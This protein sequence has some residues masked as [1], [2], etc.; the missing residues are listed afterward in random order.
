[1]FFFLCQ[2]VKFVHTFSLELL[3]MQILFNLISSFPINKVF[4]RDSTLHRF[5]HFTS[6]HYNL[7]KEVPSTYTYSKST[8]ENMGEVYFT[9]FNTLFSQFKLFAIFRITSIEEHKWMYKNLPKILHL[10]YILFFK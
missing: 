8:I 6:I 10:D 5:S 2:N 9:H 3:T 7:N 4:S 1:M